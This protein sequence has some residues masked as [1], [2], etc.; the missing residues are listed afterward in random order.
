MPD[1]LQS[2]LIQHADQLDDYKVAKD[3]VV[4]ILEAR[5][6]L[7]PDAMDTDLIDREDQADYDDDEEIDAVSKDTVCH[8]CGGKGHFASKC[9]TPKEFE[10]QSKP[11]GKGKGK[12]KANEGSPSY[13]G[14]K[15]RETVICSYC[16][17]TGHTPRTC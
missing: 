17:R 5:A 16:Q 4:S 2:S 14:Q 6:V 9:G 13:D 8:R 12:G 11:K 3:R 10:Y 1:E 15:P 7:H